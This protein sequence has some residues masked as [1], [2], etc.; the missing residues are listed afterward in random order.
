MVMCSGLQLSIEQSWDCQAHAQSLLHAYLGGDGH[1][2][3]CR[4]NLGWFEMH[5]E[6]CQQ[7]TA[8]ATRYASSHVMT[9]ACWGSYALLTWALCFAALYSC[10]F[11]LSKI[12]AAILGLLCHCCGSV[13]AMRYMYYTSIVQPL[14]C[15]ACQCLAAVLPA[16][17]GACC[18]LFTD[19][20]WRQML[21][22]KQDHS[23][24]TGIPTGV[25]SI[26]RLGGRGSEKGVLLVARKPC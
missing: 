5:R 9:L 1:H 26:H 17:Y 6:R 25:A 10:N 7:S 15:C 23:A 3:C 13:A 22:C 8:V 19:V 12:T 11:L 18:S 20:F 21:Y 16:T 4:C 14:I 24:S 2:H